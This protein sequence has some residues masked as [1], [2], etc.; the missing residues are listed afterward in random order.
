MPPRE[1]YDWL[2]AHAVE[3]ATIGSAL[4]LLHWDQSTKMPP[5][6]H[7]HRTAQVGTLTKLLH[8]RR[9]DPRVGEALD[10]ARAE[11][12]REDP[13]SEFTANVRE[14]QRAYDRAVRI[15]TELAVAT[16]RAAAEGETAWKRA[17]PDSDWQA[18][19]PH[20]E[21]IVRLRREE[22]EA[23]GYA[24]EPYDALLDEYEPGETAASL[25]PV[26]AGLRRELVPL[27][28]RILGAPRQ[29]DRTLLTR[30]YPLG[31]QRA[32]CREAVA[33]IGFDFEAGRIDPTAHPFSTRIGPGDV[34]ITTRYNEH[35]FG[36]GFFGAIHE[37]GH[38]LYSQ[39]IPGAHFGTPCGVS[40]SLGVHES[41]SR[42]WE[43]MVARSRG[44]WRHFLP[45]AEERFDCLRGVELDA[46]VLA[47][48]DVRPS[49]I[50]VEADEV[51]YNLH[52]LLRFGLELALLRGRLEP[53]D[54][55]GAWDESMRALL[56]LT[57]PDLADGVMQDVHWSAG[58]LGYFPTYTLGNL[59]AAQLFEA[60][61]REL[62]GGPQGLDERFAAGDFAPL[63]GW[64]REKVHV[65]GSR[66]V[67]R[68]LM[69]RAT[70]AELGHEAFMRYLTAKYEALYGL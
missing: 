69:R 58:L 13:E 18:F 35:A 65:H 4:A 29:P 9:T 24:N 16:A 70:G 50:R 7:A 55:P 8:E 67:P 14:W 3:T 6:G 52:V 56:G 31:C 19:L 42:L 66:F 39:G 47:V 61:G 5:A 21:E 54:L 11:L 27:L 51:T 10:K 32:L 33:A 57:P 25:E 1:S 49:L 43:N 17:R 12:L 30:H 37:A 60:A 22:A 62:G 36:E 34:R 38:A 46:F 44:F 26:L 40:V 59:Y 48:N 2:R 20:L 64:L 63:L 23:V 15:P 53:R 68:E 41:Q 45:R 28:E